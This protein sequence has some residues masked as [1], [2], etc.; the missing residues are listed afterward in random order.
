MTVLSLH[1]HS[2][3]SY[4]GGVIPMWAEISPFIEPTLRTLGLLHFGQTWMSTYF[5]CFSSALNA[6]TSS[7]RSSLSTF[8]TSK[9]PCRFFFFFFRCF[10]SDN[11]DPSDDYAF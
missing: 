1:P 6:S 3:H 11:Y 8:S 2:V 5:R 7:G 4:F 10:V 9:R